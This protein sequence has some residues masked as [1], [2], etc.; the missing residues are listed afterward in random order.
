MAPHV[1]GITV[2][3][4]KGGR[5]L[6][7]RGT[8]GE[9]QFMMTDSTSATSAAGAVVNVVDPNGQKTGSFT[10]ARIGAKT[11]TTNT[12]IAAKTANTA[13]A[14]KPTEA[15]MPT[16]AP[17]NASTSASENAY[18]KRKEAIIKLQSE[19]RNE[20]W[21]NNVQDEK[22]RE[23]IATLRN[24]IAKGIK[25]KPVDAAAK[26]ALTLVKAAAEKALDAATKTHAMLGVVKPSTTVTDTNINR[27]INVVN[28]TNYEALHAAR[29]AAAVVQAVLTVKAEVEAATKEGKAS[30]V[31]DA[32]MSN[33][34]KAVFMTN[35]DAIN[36]ALTI[37]NNAANLVKNAL[38]AVA[39]TALETKTLEQ[40]NAFMRKKEV[41]LQ[42]IPANNE[43][44]D[45]AEKW[46]TIY[47]TI[48]GIPQEGG[49]NRTQRTRKH[50]R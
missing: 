15:V 8:N 35:V 27:A 50:K 10:I 28:K 11:K 2:T 43:M 13:I 16:S 24:A 22:L 9:S 45:A 4:T 12:T 31:I 41:Y 17:T 34:T 46:I 19:S 21:K 30:I 23:K 36:Q 33:N 25:T 40:G 29:E 18:R 44:Q 3:N 47:N 42:M 20:I 6:N 26:K 32:T 48:S 39:K 7:I 38:I 1:M 5:I 49:R 37:S 14:I